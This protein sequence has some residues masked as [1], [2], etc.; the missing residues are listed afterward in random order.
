MGRVLKPLSYRT[1]IS[2]QDVYEAILVKK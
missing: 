2:L 1:D